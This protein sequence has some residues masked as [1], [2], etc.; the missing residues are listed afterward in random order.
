MPFNIPYSITELQDY[1]NRD[2]RNSIEIKINNNEKISPTEIL[3]YE[4]F[5]FNEIAKNFAKKHNLNFI[6]TLKFFNKSNN[7]DYFIDMTHLND[8][9]H[10]KYY[11]IMKEELK[12]IYKF[13][14]Y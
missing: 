11:Q 13:N 4:M 8:T 3:Y 7:K 1:T 2:S 12:K 14:K 10:I 5:D 9:G 6:D